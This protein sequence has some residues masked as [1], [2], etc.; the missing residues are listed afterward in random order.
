MRLKSPAW[1]PP[2]T[3]T[4]P[5][6]Y[7]FIEGSKRDSLRPP[8]PRHPRP[9]NER[10]RNSALGLTA[11]DPSARVTGRRGFTSVGRSYE[12]SGEIL[13]MVVRH[14]R[15]PHPVGVDGPGRC[16]GPV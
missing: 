9:V 15:G 12:D 7:F 16:P 2:T 14:G 1:S 5:F 8:P 4:V 3:E 13:F 10:G 11:W 6:Q